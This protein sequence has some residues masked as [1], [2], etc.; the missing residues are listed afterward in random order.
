MGATSPGRWQPW[1]RACKI[2]A[3]SLWKVICEGTLAAIAEANRHAPSVS[4]RTAIY[5]PPVIASIS[6]DGG[7]PQSH[8]EH[9]LYVTGD[10]T[11]G[12]R[13]V[14]AV[15]AGA[16]EILDHG[17]GALVVCFQAIADDLHAVVVAAD[18][19]SAVGIAFAVSYGRLRQQIVDAQTDPALA[20]RRQARNQNGLWNVQMDDH[21]RIESL[22]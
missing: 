17:P 9:R 5:T 15:H 22:L 6:D 20:A 18:E 10:G 2:G 14:D 13:A 16:A 1:Q 12:W 4:K 19:R 3:T 21:G 11:R 8:V 7:L